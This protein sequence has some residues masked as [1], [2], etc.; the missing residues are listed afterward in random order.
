MKRIVQF[1]TAAALAGSA[2]HSQSPLP[3]I[4]VPP[5]TT[6]DD[7]PIGNTTTLGIAWQA[8][9]LIA[10]DLR[11]TAETMAIPPEQK[12]YYSYPEVTAP[13]F[14][15]WRAKGAKA[16]LTGFVR[17][18]PD[19][20]L[21][22]G[23]YIY[24][25]EKGRELGRTGFV[26]DADDWR[27]AAH[28]CSGLAYQSLIGTP[29][30]FDTRIT[31]VAKTGVGPA[32]V[33]RVALMDGDGL[34]HSYVTAGDTLVMSPR[35]SPKADR[36]AYVR[37]AGGT[38]HIWVADL[39]SGDQRPLIP[40][41]LTSFAPRF[42]PDGSRIVFS[43]I[44]GGNSDIYVVNATGGIPQRLTSSPGID[45]DPSLSPDGSKILFE[46][47]RSGSQQL[48]VMD[49][50]GANQRRIS[51][52]VGWYAA[53]EWSPDGEKIAFTNR[54]N[55]G[56]RVGVMNADGSGPRLLTSGPRDEG[57]NWAASSR[58]LIFQRV[59]GAGRSGIYRV[60]LAGGEPRKITV[61]QDGADPDWSGARE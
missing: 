56:L 36:L 22:V 19:G 9:Q 55:G 48:Y 16:L 10:T 34:N 54:S 35:I 58:E 29:G 12:D 40:G 17:A 5:L 6:P 4:A 30:A 27:R 41:T 20:R 15:R 25:V 31:Y 53:P 33:S 42:S 14:S 23:C 39:A 45:T 50:S 37:F 28:K 57:P 3:V 21:A 44:N 1:L 13:T 38:P 18:Q 26:V 7:K 60:P 32:Q 51:F 8:S 43:M 11:S 61:P 46:S 47:D 24:D 2:A 59:D 49:A 52:G